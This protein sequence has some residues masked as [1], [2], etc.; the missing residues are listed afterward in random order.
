MRIYKRNSEISRTVTQMGKLMSKSFWRY[1]VTISSSAQTHY[2]GNLIPLLLLEHLS[3]WML[4]VL[5]V[6]NAVNLDKFCDWWIHS[7]FIL[8]VCLGIMHFDHRLPFAFQEQFRNFKNWIILNF[9][10]LEFSMLTEVDPWIS[11]SLLLQWTALI[12]QIQKTSLRKFYLF[13]SQMFTYLTVLSQLD[14]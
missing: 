14:F 11:W 8:F 10:F 4:K 7:M 9:C 5:T 6:T 12:L 3:S 1:S 13:S 2:S